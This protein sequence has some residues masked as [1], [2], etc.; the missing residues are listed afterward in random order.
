MKLFRTRF[1]RD[2]AQLGERLGLAE[3]F[4]QAHRR[5]A[6]DRVGDELLD[7]RAPRRGADHRQ[8]VRFTVGVDADVA[9]DELAGALELG[10]R[11]QGGHEHGVP[12]VG[13]RRQASLTRASYAAWSISD[14]V[15]DAS[16]G[17]I[18]KNQPAPSGSLLASDGSARSASLTSTTSPPIGM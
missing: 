14:D 11:L 13:G 6:R 9:G 12:V 7:Q 10:K 3:R 18:L 16:L 2:A 1:C 5:R 15:S 17:L 4:R 8:H